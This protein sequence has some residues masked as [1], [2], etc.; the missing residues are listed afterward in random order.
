MYDCKKPFA[1]IALGK[2]GKNR[3]T[4]MAKLI[5]T[6]GGAEFRPNP[7][8]IC[9][10]SPR[11]QEWGCSI[12]LFICDSTMIFLTCL[13]QSFATSRPSR[14]TNLLHPCVR[15]PAVLQTLANKAC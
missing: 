7:N 12:H 11:W 6:P 3:D 14:A 9:P 4:I 10:K 2:G 13:A 15:N 8:Q 1:T 5:P